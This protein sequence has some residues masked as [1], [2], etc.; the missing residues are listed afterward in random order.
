MPRRSPDSE[1]DA[2]AMVTA[3]LTA[4]RLLV[5]VSARSLAAV[6]DS[7][8]LPQ[9]RML[10]VL[11]GRGPLSLSGLAGEMGVQPS[12]AMRMIDRLVAAGMVARGV[13]AG[14]RRTSVISLTKLGRRIVSEATGRR[15]QE[16]A[17]IVDAM[18]PGQRRYLIEAL[19]AF[20]EAGGE[21]AVGDGPQVHATW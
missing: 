20:T 1:S 7:L 16:I 8:T 17:R 6:E 9:F 4:S 19:Q 18:P 14:D 15:R 2:E 5:A 21:P 3:L 10:V 12:T 13:S 11:D